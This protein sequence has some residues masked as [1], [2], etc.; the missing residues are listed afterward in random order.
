MKKVVL[1]YKKGMDF[2]DKRYVPVYNYT[3]TESANTILSV[4]GAVKG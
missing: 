2:V 3:C 4:V 1:F